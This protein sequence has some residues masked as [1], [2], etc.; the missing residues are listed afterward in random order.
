[1][2]WK[3]FEKEIV[4]E[5]KACNKDIYV[6]TSLYRVGKISG[7]KRQ[8]DILIEEGY[9]KEKI[10]TVID[11]KFY[12]KKVD[13]K[14]AE[15]FIGM[16]QDLGVKR[17][18]IISQKGLTKSAIKRIENDPLEIGYDILDLGSLMPFQGAGG[19]PYSGGQGVLLK[20]PFGWI[21]DARRRLGMVAALYQR[22]KSFED[23]IDGG[24]FMYINYWHNKNGDNLK[25]CLKQQE[26]TLSEGG[27]K[28]WEY[29]KL[30][31]RDDAKVKLR[32][33]PHPKQNTVEYTGFVEFKEAT[34]FCVLRTT[35]NAEKKN[36]EKLINI[37]STILPV[38]IKHE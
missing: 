5:L 36:K 7:R 21:I 20:S 31:V 25:K 13:I 11:G 6:M 9:G 1:M 34:F 24:E 37:L 33:A 22:G 18:L 16:L 32:I 38:T 8:I 2:D 30:K 35:R 28:T 12:N 14:K 4:S 29:L 23:A 3:Q 19:I 26:K 10:T 27:F 15:S 17:G